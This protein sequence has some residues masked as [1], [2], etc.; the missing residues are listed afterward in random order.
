MNYDLEKILPH[1]RPMILIDDIIE[2]LPDENKIKTV[3]TIKEKALFYDK[4]TKGVSSVTG[5]EYMAQTVGCY[6]FLKD[7]LPEPKIGF[8]LGSR[9]YKS[10]I[11][12]FSL[13][14]TYTIEAN[15]IFSGNDIVSFDCLIYNQ[16]KEEIANATL[17]VYQAKGNKEAGFN[18]EV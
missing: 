3:V 11:D 1:K 7:N 2:Y 8:L 12:K 9:L 4:K 18:A 10:K 13:D 5:I 15:E 6:A 17:N 14:E 16:Q